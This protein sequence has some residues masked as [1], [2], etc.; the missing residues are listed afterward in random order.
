MFLYHP[1]SPPPCVGCSLLEQKVDEL[2]VK[3]AE[4]ARRLQEREDK[5]LQYKRCSLG[6]T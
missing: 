2:N 3:T 5:A 4:N 6:W 1:M